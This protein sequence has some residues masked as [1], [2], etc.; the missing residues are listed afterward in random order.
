[1]QSPDESQVW[2]PGQSLWGLI[3]EHISESELPK[4]YTALGHSL[5]DVYTDM[6]T[7]AEM[8]HKMWQEN[9]RSG[10]HGGVAGT[11][12]PRLQGAPLV[13][14]PAVKELLR[15]EVKM[16]LQ[17]LG[18]KA[19]RAG[20]DVE[21]LLH[22]YKP[23]T[24]NYALG[25]RDRCHTNCT[26]PEDTDSGSRPDSR[27]SVQSRAED[28]I[29]AVRG[30]LN[31]TEI[32]QV[33]DRLRALLIGECEELT[34]LV[35]H[36]KANIKQKCH[37]GLHKSEPSLA[38]LRELRGAIQVDLELSPFLF[39]PSSPLPAKKGF[40]LTA[41][42]SSESLKTLSPPSVLRPHPPPPLS[43]PI[44]RPPARPRLSKMSTSRTHEQDSA[45]LSCR[46]P[47]STANFEEKSE[48]NSP[49]HKTHLSVNCRI[50]SQ[51]R[52]CEWS[53]Q[54][55]RKSSPA[56]RPRNINITPSPVPAPSGL[57]NEGSCSSKSTDQSVAAKWNSGIQKRQQDS[58]CEGSLESARAQSYADSRRKMS[59]NSVMSETRRTPA[60]TC[61]RK[62]NG[63]TS[64]NLSG[65][66]RNDGKEQQNLGGQ[67]ATLCP[68]H[69]SAACSQR[70]PAKINEYFF[71]SSKKPQGG[72]TSQ[73]K[74]PAEP[75]FLQRFHQPVPPTRVQ[76]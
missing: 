47:D 74:E 12:L 49:L 52:E 29:E 59:E 4:I 53:P 70:P 26:N 72:S 37:S 13:D 1:M 8:W 63:E 32:D 67:C 9:Q 58:S 30:K 60:Q 25:H 21:E 66:F 76:T 73:P 10:K 24:L 45:G 23:E 43:P 22:R 35:K 56:Y 3:A 48:R 39:P 65:A 31:V 61:R 33:V 16:L 51:S 34:R 15:A 41:A 64:R 5:V 55:E 50:H 19:S 75:Q 57:C 36:I 18:E 17:T 42:Q 62:S 54:R 27:C 71:T 20:R 7:E 14:P 2:G 11:P 6:H 69:P 68:S 40:R 38:D 46:T 44:P 28:E